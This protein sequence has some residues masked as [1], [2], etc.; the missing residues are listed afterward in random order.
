MIDTE[1]AAVEWLYDNIICTEPVV[2][3]GGSQSS[4]LQ[5]LV[6]ELKALLQQFP[7]AIR[8]KQGS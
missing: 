8:V 1:A 6:D 7:H 3:S 5:V 2:S 4:S